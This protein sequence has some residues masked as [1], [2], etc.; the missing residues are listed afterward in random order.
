LSIE[1][2]IIERTL[3]DVITTQVRV[4]A[5]RI[6]VK[7]LT[8]NGLLFSFVSYELLVPMPEFFINPV[9]L[10]FFIPFKPINS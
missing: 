6:R 8:D 4:I 10:S 3:I 1:I 2:F 7:V 9:T 5:I